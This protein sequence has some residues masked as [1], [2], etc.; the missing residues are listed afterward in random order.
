MGHSS[1]R[2]KEIEVPRGLEVS[3]KQG[4]SSEFVLAHQMQIPNRRESSGETYDMPELKCTLSAGLW[5]LLQRHAHQN[6]QPIAHVVNQ[7][8]AD[9]FGAAHHT[10]YQVPTFSAL[11]EGIYKG[12]VRV[13]LLGMDS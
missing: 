2:R 9:Y 1:D 8:L 12:A 10:L 6:H 3:Q 13:P 11:V 4:P 7:A 5:E